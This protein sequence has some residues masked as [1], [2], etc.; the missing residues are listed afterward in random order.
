[1]RVKVF[2][3]IALLAASIAVGSPADATPTPPVILVNHSTEQC[4]E[5]I[6]GDDCHWCEPLEGW[7]VLGY[8]SGTTCPDG[9]EDLGYQG[10]TGQCRAYKNQFC[11]TDYSHHGDC[12]DLVINEAE[13]LCAFVEEIEGCTLPEGWTSAG[14][15]TQ[16]SGRCPVENQ[17]VGD[18]ACVAST[19]VVEPTATAQTA[20]ATDTP[21]ATDMPT[22]EAAPSPTTPPEPSLVE[23]PRTGA[24]WAAIIALAGLLAIAVWFGFRWLRQ[25]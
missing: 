5:V 16:W 20:A 17:W 24:V 2:L 18:I 10:M 12:E 3:L 9:Y 1:M 21:T 14:D 11:C 8:S 25:R 15:T 6:H 7:E 4:A 13:Q 19:Q 23:Y 22:A